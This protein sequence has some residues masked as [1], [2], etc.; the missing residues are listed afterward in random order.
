MKHIGATLLCI[1]SQADAFHCGLNFRRPSRATTRIRPLVKDRH[2]GAHVVRVAPLGELEEND[3][4]RT[5]FENFCHGA[6]ATFQEGLFFKIQLYQWIPFYATLEIGKLSDQFLSPTFNQRLFKL[7]ENS[8]GIG[9]AIMGQ[10]VFLTSTIPQFLVATVLLA[11][12]WSGIYLALTF[13]QPRAVVLQ[14][15]E[16]FKKMRDIGD[17]PLPL[18]VLREIIALVQVCI[19]LPLFEEVAFRVL[20]PYAIHQIMYIGRAKKEKRPSDNSTTVTICS[21]LFAVAHLETALSAT[22]G[23]YIIGQVNRRLTLAFLMAQ[24]IVAPTFQEQGLVAAWG[25]HVSFNSAAIV[26]VMVWKSLVGLVAK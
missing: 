10:F 6:K 8:C 26:S 9:V 5:G 19:L 18:T 25:A 21:I 20:L 2:T 16:S 23:K 22:E 17:V 12:A 24:R 3:S 14:K 7:F 15:L 11:A 4:I 1:I 13:E